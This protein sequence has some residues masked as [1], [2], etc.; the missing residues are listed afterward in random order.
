MESNILKGMTR[1]EALKG[2]VTCA[3]SADEAAFV[4]DGKFYSCPSDFN[5]TGTCGNNNCHACWQAAINAYFDE[6]D[7]PRWVEPKVAAITMLTGKSAEIFFSKLFSEEAET[8]IAR[9]NADRKVRAFIRANGGSG[10]Y[11]VRF[12][13]DDND[14]I[15]FK[16]WGSFKSP[17]LITCATEA[18]ANEVIRRFSAELK[19]LMEG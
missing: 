7:K 3:K 5:L 1:V 6:Q 14:F 15:P 9:T 2:V 17:G 8:E 13:T 11:E 16:V 10:E 18:L 12:D 4:A 19:L